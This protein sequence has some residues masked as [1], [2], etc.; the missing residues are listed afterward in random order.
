MLEKKKEIV[1]QSVA[2][3]ACKTAEVQEDGESDLGL[4]G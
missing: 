2:R 3:R 1:G 4:Q